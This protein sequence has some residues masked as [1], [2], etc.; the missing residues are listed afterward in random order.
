[1]KDR[2]FGCQLFLVTF[3]SLK[4]GSVYGYSIVSNNSGT[5]Y[6]TASS[7]CATLNMSVVIFKAYGKYIR[8]KYAML[9]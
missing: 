8:L 6:F 9:T 4:F 3:L 5:D 1:M 7:C 2:E